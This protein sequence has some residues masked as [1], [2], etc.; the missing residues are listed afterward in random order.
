MTPHYDRSSSQFHVQ[1]PIRLVYLLA[2][3][4]VT[5]SSYN[6]SSSERKT[7][8]IVKY[9]LC[10]SIIEKVRE[11]QTEGEAAEHLA[12]RVADQL[13]EPRTV[14][15]MGRLQFVYQVVEYTGL[16]TYFL[17][18]PRRLENE[19]QTENQRNAEKRRIYAG[20]Y[21]RAEC[22]CCHERRVRT[23]H[24]T[25]VE[26]PKHVETARP[27]QFDH[28]LEQ[29]RDDAGHYGGNTDFVYHTSGS[30]E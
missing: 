16:I 8:F 20:V 3:Q 18:K 4:A 14:D 10:S 5:T 27:D 30:F 12:P 29:L 7:V 22:E 1:P 24:T 21:A 11:Q 17:P 26:K 23:G 19:V 25:V 9:F 2:C 15:V 13:L 28:N 6:A